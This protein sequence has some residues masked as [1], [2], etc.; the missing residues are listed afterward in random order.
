[1]DSDYLRGC[2]QIV[3]IDKHLKL[4]R[5]HH[6]QRAKMGRGDKV[7]PVDDNSAAKQDTAQ[8]L[9]DTMFQHYFVAGIDDAR[10]S[11][12]L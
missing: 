10:I 2:S 11:N 3:Y 8:V 9:G 6:K 5:V 4:H 7:A 1:V 12:D